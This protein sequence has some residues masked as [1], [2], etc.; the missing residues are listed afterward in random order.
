MT[1]PDDKFVFISEEERA[2]MR[3]A[4]LAS[5]VDEARLAVR[6]ARD[7]PSEGNWYR[8]IGALAALIGP[9]EAYALLRLAVERGA[10]DKGR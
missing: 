10:S 6:A 8:V 5:A 7:D 2:E 4:L 3:A 1:T 9:D